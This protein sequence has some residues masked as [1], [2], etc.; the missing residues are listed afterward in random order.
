LRTALVRSLRFCGS[1]T[2]PEAY[3]IE[4]LDA[5]GERG[6]IAA[7]HAQ[8]Y[9]GL[10]ERGEP[11]STARPSREWLADYV[12]EIDNLRAALDWAFSPGGDASIR[13]ALTA[14]AVPLWI[15]LSLLQERRARAK[16]A[17]GAHGTR[18]ARDPRT[19]M[20][21]RR[22]A[23]LIDASGRRDGRGGHEG[24]R[25]C[26][27]PWRPRIP[28]ARSPRRLFL[29]QRKRSISCGAPIRAKGL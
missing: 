17:I 5:G 7:R 14:A 23:G 20:K 4:M 3:A 16:Q 27:E 1:S 12:G 13:P 8:Y 6:R 22:G 18:L 28:A 26:G 21:L 29:S 25:N 24:A 2:R 15:R 11:E 10:F 19:E 9:R